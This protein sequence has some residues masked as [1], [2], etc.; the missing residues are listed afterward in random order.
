MYSIYTCSFSSV[1]FSSP[2]SSEHELEESLELEL[3]SESSSEE[4]VDDWEIIDVAV[5]VG[6]W[7]IFP[8]WEFSVVGVATPAAFPVWGIFT[9]ACWATLP[10]AA[11][12]TGWG[13][14]FVFGDGLEEEGGG[15]ATLPVAREFKVDACVVFTMVAIEVFED[16]MIVG[17]VIEVDETEDCEVTAIEL[18]IDFVSEFEDLIDDL[19]LVGSNGDELFEG[20]MVVIFWAELCWVMKE[21]AGVVGFEDTVNVVLAADEVDDKEL[22]T[23]AAASLVCLWWALEAFTTDSIASSMDSLTVSCVVRWPN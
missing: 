17:V 20:I 16:D 13:W 2:L 18:D 22:E 21:V 14:N 19:I 15:W 8:T 7:A 23:A 9:D 5:M 10:G 4:A 3:E 11:V 12:I 1:S 6:A